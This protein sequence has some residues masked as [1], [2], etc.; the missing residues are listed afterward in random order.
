MS[1]LS[2]AGAAV[3][4][5]ALGLAACSSGPAASP[6]PVAVAVTLEEWAVGTSVASVPAG[7]VRFTVT[8][9]GPDDLHEFVV[10]KTDLSLVALPTDETGKVN[11]DAGGMVVIGEIEDILVGST[12]ELTV[13]LQ[14][15]AYV[16][17]C[18]IYTA[19]ENEAHYQEGMRTSFTVTP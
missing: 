5:A 7:Q 13:S 17:L 8:N 2:I 14:P 15:G 9:E 18:N 3:A 6:T 11:E 16:L 10:M 1:R 4:A 12:E 19:E